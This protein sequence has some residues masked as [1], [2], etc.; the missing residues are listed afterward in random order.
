MD[1]KTKK[2][3]IVGAA[4]SGIAVA[5]FALDQGARV[6]IT[7]QQPLDKIKQQLNDLASNVEIESG[8]TEDFIASSDMLILSPGVPK[9]SM[10]VLWAQQH[11]IPI[12]NEIELA[13]QF[14]HKP[15]IAV[16][17]S[18]GKTTTATLISLVLDQAG[19]RVSLVGNIGT[20]FIGEVCRTD[21]DYY[22]LEVSSFQLEWIEQF[23]P[24]IAIFLNFS[25]NHLDRH[26]DID[27][28][29]NAKARLFMNQDKTDIALLNKEDLRVSQ[30]GPLLQAQVYYFND[31]SEKHTFQNPNYDAVLKVARLLNIP[32]KICCG[33][34]EQ[35]KGVEH[36]MEYVCTI[37]GVDFIN[38]SKSTTVASGQWALALMTKPV[39]MI[40]GGRDKNSD[41]SVIKDSIKKKVV[42]MVV[43]GEA[44]AKL[45]TAFG[46]VVPVRRVNMLE[47][48]V[49]VAREMVKSDEIVLLSPMCASFDQF[50]NFEQ[51]GEVFKS[52]VN[53]RFRSK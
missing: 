48:A 38:D 19:K 51:R 30:L 49:C 45:E 16:T 2:V 4:R 25:Q 32:D 7:D 21:I 28:Y 5:R 22:V 23:C 18:N 12:V 44:G 27:D 11:H 1:L 29:F 3:C 50:A 37:D 43:Y 8:H 34:F 42:G 41:F 13:S 26:D 9:K 36:R 20:P 10:P 35:F 52:I 46:N 47:E 24:F 33:V 15:I 14:C 31:A 6:K 39:V 53:N 40:A 17:G